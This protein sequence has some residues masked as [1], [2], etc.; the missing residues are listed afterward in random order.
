MGFFLLMLL[1]IGLRILGIFL[2]LNGTSIKYMVLT[3]EVAG[4][5]GGGTSDILFVYDKVCGRNCSAV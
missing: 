1:T 4:I 3:F 5:V 2:L